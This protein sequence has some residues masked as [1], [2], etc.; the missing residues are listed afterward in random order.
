MC[1]PHSSLPRFW[2]LSAWLWRGPTPNCFGNSTQ[3]TSPRTNTRAR[4]VSTMLAVWLS[5]GI[6]ESVSGFLF[7]F[8]GVHF[9]FLPAQN[10]FGDE[11]NKKLR[12]I[13][14]LLLRILI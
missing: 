10:A 1:F 7:T 8:G 6:S 11:F 3:R 12:A 2:I 5:A 9:R 4:A 13:K 14:L